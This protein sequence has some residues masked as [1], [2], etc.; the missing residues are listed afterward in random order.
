MIDIYFSIFSAVYDKNKKNVLKTKCEILQ[1]SSDCQK[2][3]L[4]TDLFIK[5]DYIFLI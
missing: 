2:R 1:T 5:S 3:N 4:M